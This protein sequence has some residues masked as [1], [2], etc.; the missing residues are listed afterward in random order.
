MDHTVVIDQDEDGP[1]H[2]RPSSSMLRLDPEADVA[3]TD[4]IYYFS[5]LVFLVKGRLFK[6]PRIFFET[7]SAIFKNMFMLPNGVE[8]HDPEG[9]S[10]ANPIHLEGVKRK[11][12]AAF[13]KLLIPLNP[14]DPIHLEKEEWIGALEISTMW[15]FKRIRETAIPGLDSQTMDVTERII[16]GH[17]YGIHE[18]ILPAYIELATRKT[19]PT[20]E[21]VNR[22]GLVFSLKLFEAREKII[23]ATALARGFKEGRDGGSNFWP[24]ELEREVSYTEIFASVFGKDFGDFLPSF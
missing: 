17:K 24:H 3:D 14:L 13:L 4:P 10:D 2:E 22:L 5:L 1:S 15:E 16:F 9:S 19:A 18:W 7:Q 20:I 12:F 8:N 21:E 6:V 11:D 23:N